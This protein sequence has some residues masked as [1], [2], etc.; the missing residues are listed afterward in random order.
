MEGPSVAMETVVIDEVATVGHSLCEYIVDAVQSDLT[1]LV[2]FYHSGCQSI[3]TSQVTSHT[4]VSRWS[5]LPQRVPPAL[6]CV[7]HRSRGVGKVGYL[8][9]PR[10][11]RS[12]SGLKTTFV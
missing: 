9:H 6:L 10:F 5:I 7:K 8:M 12:K 1:R 11:G 2:H 3:S 4:G